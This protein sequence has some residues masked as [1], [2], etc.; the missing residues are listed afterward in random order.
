MFEKAEISRIKEKI[1][2]LMKKK[3][4]VLQDLRNNVSE[5]RCR[6]QELENSLEQIRNAAN[7]Y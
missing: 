6:N 1:L 2:V 7:Y 3:Q 4:S 5:L